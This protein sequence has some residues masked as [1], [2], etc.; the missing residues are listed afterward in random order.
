MKKK[1]K[2]T[3]VHTITAIVLA[4]AV[5]F[6]TGC[7]NGEKNPYQIDSPDATMTIDILYSIT[8]IEANNP[9]IGIEMPT[10]FSEQKKYYNSLIRMLEKEDNF[11]IVDDVSLFSL[12][13][14]DHILDGGKHIRL[15]NKIRDY[16]YSD[17]IMSIYPNDGKNTCPESDRVINCIN[18]C[19]GLRKA[20]EGIS[21]QELMELGIL[22]IFKKVYID[23]I[24]ENW[25]ETAD[26]MEKNYI[27]C[28]YTEL[29]LLAYVRDL[30]SEFDFSLIQSV[31]R[32]IKLSD[33]EKLIAENS[34]E[35]AADLKQ[36][37]IEAV[38]YDKNETLDHYASDMFAEL[39][40]YSDISDGF[41]EW[42]GLVSYL[43]LGG[44]VTE[45]RYYTENINQW[46]DKS[47]EN[48]ASVYREK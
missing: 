45:N 33:L 36:M 25:Y 8:R 10:C 37:S 3:K 47:F 18:M 7:V 20:G 6:T 26:E 30:T 46:L 16:Q 4:I 32:V 22:D 23:S 31:Q 14:I 41:I 28:M 2:L 24:D 5:I 48:I 34:I 13:Y 27:L 21:N 17:G 35:N 12:L 44:I 42:A 39:N 1:S 11:S 40:S 29:I 19:Y 9:S 43:E 38:V 15:V